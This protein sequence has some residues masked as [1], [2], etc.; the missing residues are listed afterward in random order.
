MQGA[1]R[2]CEGGIGHLQHPGAWTGRRSGIDGVERA[3]CGQGGHSRWGLVTAQ[4][5][6]QQ[7]AET[8]VWWACA[9]GEDRWDAPAAGTLEQ[10]QVGHARG[11]HGA[12]AGS[13]WARERGAWC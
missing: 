8:G 6:L 2:E 12:G 3:A 7:G 4:Q 11:G 5:G 1:G 9:R 10:V 13:G